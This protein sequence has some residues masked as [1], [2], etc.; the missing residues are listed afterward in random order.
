[1]N[2]RQDHYYSSPRASE[3]IPY[4]PTSTVDCERASALPDLASLRQHPGRLKHSIRLEISRRP[5][6]RRTEVSTG[7]QLTQPHLTSLPE[8]K[9]TKCLSYQREVR[10]C[11]YITLK[12]FSDGCLGSRNDEERSEMR[13]VVVTS[14]NHAGRS[15]RLAMGMSTT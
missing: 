1:M 13:Y 2:L 7:F 14:N 9:S 3:A 8:T 10:L 11:K 12:T 15:I 5:P 4:Q 6:L